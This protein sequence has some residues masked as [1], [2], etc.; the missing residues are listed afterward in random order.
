MMAMLEVS[1]IE[2]CGRLSRELMPTSMVSLGT[3]ERMR[4]Q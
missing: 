2:D 4:G 3:T 1:L